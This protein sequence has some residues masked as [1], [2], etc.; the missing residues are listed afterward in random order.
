METL[1]VWKSFDLMSRAARCASWQENCHDLYAAMRFPR[2]DLAILALIKTLSIVV[3]WPLKY[4][5]MAFLMSFAVLSRRQFTWFWWRH[6]HSCVHLQR[7]NKIEME[8]I[9]KFL[10]RSVSFLQKPG[11]FLPSF[12]CSSGS[13]EGRKA[14]LILF[15]SCFFSLHP[16]CGSSA[17]PICLSLSS[18]SRKLPIY[19]SLVFCLPETYE[20]SNFYNLSERR[21]GSLDCNNELWRAWTFGHSRKRQ[22]KS[23]R[24]N[25]EKCNSDSRIR[26]KDVVEERDRTR[27][28]FWEIVFVLVCRLVDSSNNH[29]YVKDIIFSD[30]WQWRMGIFPKNDFA[31]IRDGYTSSL[32]YTS[33]PSFQI[34]R[35]FL[36]VIWRRAVAAPSALFITPTEIQ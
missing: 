21:S 16:L 24:L 18:R 12:F 31:N 14:I 8:N 2:G 9:V 23:V 5:L 15:V 28:M 6:F 35:S 32:E 22:N 17:F 13:P 10:V 1:K 30:M 34:F 7:N 19:C 26:W 4:N 33:A 25:R 36:D 3:S 29:L 11:S 27:R 20:N